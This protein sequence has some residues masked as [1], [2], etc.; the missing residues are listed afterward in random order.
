MAKREALYH[1]P[2]APGFELFDVKLPSA[3]YRLISQFLF[4]KL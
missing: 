4:L 3:F 1:P 2:F